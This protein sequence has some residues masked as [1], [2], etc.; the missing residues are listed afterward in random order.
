M[1]YIRTRAIRE[2]NRQVQLRAWAGLSPKEKALR[3]AGMDHS[4]LKV[5]HS[6]PR[7]EKQLVAFRRGARK[8]WEKET[9]RK[10]LPIAMKAAWSAPR[11]K[12][13]MA[14]L[15][16]ARKLIP[17]GAYCVSI[18]QMFVFKRL[19]K[20]GVNGVK[21]N[22]PLGPYALDVALPKRK[23]CIEVDGRY[24]HSLGYTNYKKRDKFLRKEGWRVYRFVVDSRK[25]ARE[26]F[27]NVLWFL[28]LG[29]EEG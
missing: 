3:V 29:G 26:K 12:K 25:E 16:E 6:L 10:S 14:A 28:G 5:A 21:L 17:R 8:S 22:Y 24:W 13:Q 2:K 9:W 4:G 18:S 1:S 7:T 27:S 20:L 23:L 15:V 11:T 19:C